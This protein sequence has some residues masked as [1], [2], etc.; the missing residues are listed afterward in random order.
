MPEINHP[1]Y[2]PPVSNARTVVDDVTFRVYRAGVA[3]M[4][5][6]SDDYRITITPID[7]GFGGRAGYYTV[8][9][10]GVYLV[11]AGGDR[12]KRFQSRQNAM[13]AGVKAFRAKGAIPHSR[14]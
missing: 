8:A 5:T 4:V 7:G 14:L 9:L 11:G 10:D 2:G 13:K 6:C 1:R 12:A 3:R